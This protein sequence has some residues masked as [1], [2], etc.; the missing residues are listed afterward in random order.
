MGKYK[1]VKPEDVIVTENN[2][3]YCLNRT[4]W[5]VLYYGVFQDG[6]PVYDYTDNDVA[7]GIVYDLV[8]AQCGDKIDEEE[9]EHEMDYLCVNVSETEAFQRFVEEREKGDNLQCY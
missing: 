5:S 2:V 1:A 6:E 8:Y 7:C 4:P 3:Q 9:L